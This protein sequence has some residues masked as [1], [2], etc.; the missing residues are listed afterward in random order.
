VAITR[1]VPVRGVVSVLAMKAA[2]IVPLLVPLD[3][4]WI[5]SQLPPAVTAAVQLIVP[6]P[7][8][9]MSN[10]VVPV[11]YTTSLLLGFTLRTGSA[12]TVKLTGRVAFP[13]LLFVFVKVTVS[14]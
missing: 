9:E 8:F 7:V 12:V 5:V 14:P 11:V 4:D 10:V 1:I 6:P 3:P 13:M 2:V